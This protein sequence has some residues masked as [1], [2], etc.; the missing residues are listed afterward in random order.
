MYTQDYFRISLERGQIHGG[1]FKASTNP[2]EEP[3][4]KDRESQL[5]KGGG[6]HPEINTVCQ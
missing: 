4:V 2:R 1:K 3:H 6:K 5:P